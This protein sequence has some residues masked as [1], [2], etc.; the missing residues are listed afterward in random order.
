LSRQIRGGYP[1]LPAD[2]IGPKMPRPRRE[3]HRMLGN[4]YCT[5]LHERTQLYGAQPTGVDHRR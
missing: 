5:R 4:G 3:H 1:V 2:A